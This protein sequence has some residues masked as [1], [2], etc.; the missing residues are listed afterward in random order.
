MFD[1]LIDRRNLPGSVRPHVKTCS[2]MSWIVL[3]EVTSSTRFFVPETET[4]RDL[5]TPASFANTRTTLTFEFIQQCGTHY[6]VIWSSLLYTEITWED[7]MQY[8]P[9]KRSL[10]HFCGISISIIIFYCIIQYEIV[11][12]YRFLCLSWYHDISKNLKFEK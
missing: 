3:G 7:G 6:S 9:I 2:G 8:T 10:N 5:V 1:I 11:L 4:K 12:R